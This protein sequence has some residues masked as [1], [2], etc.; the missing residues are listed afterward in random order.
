MY[1]AVGPAVKTPTEPHVSGRYRYEMS[2][3]MYRALEGKTYSSADWMLDE[4]WKAIQKI[5]V[6]VFD[7][8]GKIQ[9]RWMPPLLAKRFKASQKVHEL[10]KEQLE[11]WS[12]YWLLQRKY[13]YDRKF[14]DLLL[15]FR[16][17]HLEEKNSHHA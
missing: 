12:M 8:A 7:T 13:G 17:V 15:E 11:L 16:N 1:K 14:S 9:L 5:Q 4:A 10:R 2:W 6:L 3:E